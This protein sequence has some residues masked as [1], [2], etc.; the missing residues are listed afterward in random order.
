MNYPNHLVQK[1]ETDKA[2]VK[3]IQKQ[4]NLCGCGPVGVDGDF[5]AKTTAAV[6][7]FQARFTDAN[8]NP[9]KVDGTIGAITW[10]ALFGEEKVKTTEVAPNI[11]LT[12]SLD[13]ARK[14]IGIMEVPLGSNSGPDVSKYQDLVGIPHGLP[15]CMAFV[16][17]N[18]NEASKKLQRKNPLVKTGGVL[19]HWN[20]ATCK[21]ILAADAAADP[22]L[23]KP[24]QIFII[25]TGA[26]TGHTGLVEKVEG[27]MLTTIEGNTNDGG[28]REGIGVFRRTARKINSINKGF[29]QYV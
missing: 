7:L 28:S 13:F 17:W 4:L 26:G 10:A 18:F 2:L 24:G 6:K 11:L 22:S 16:Y 15:W 9:L 25:S 1:G 3:A 8:G 14:E 27:G 23:V 5:G 19:A 20:Q 29:L 21:K 12:I